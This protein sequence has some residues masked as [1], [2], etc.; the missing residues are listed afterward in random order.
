M[1]R[2]ARWCREGLEANFSVRLTKLKYQF[3][4]QAIEMQ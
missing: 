1:P 4:P 3:L 2:V